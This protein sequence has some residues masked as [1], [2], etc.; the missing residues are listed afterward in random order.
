MPDT[1]NQKERLK[2]AIIRFSYKEDHD[3][4]FQLASGKTSPY[5]LD[6]KQILLQPEYLRLSAKILLDHILNILGSSPIA[7]AGLSMGADPL[8]YGISLEAIQRGVTILPFIIR[9]K[10][11]DHG[12]KK[13]IEGR[14]LDIEPRQE[15]I[16]IDDVVTTGNS[17]LKA[18]EALKEVGLEANHAFSLVDREEG[19][20][21]N[22]SKEGIKIYSVFKLKDLKNT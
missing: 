18:Y 13:K 15:V 10:E 5:Y 21:L 8:I 16:L 2:N 7:M 3:A 22:F 4:P 12:S 1:T 19:S 14:Y 6:L 17:T 11:K 9:K 20:L